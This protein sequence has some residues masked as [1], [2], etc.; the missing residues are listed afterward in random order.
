MAHQHKIGHSS[1]QEQQMTKTIL[2]YCTNKHTA[3]LDE[4]KSNSGLPV[5]KQMTL[6]SNNSS[7]VQSAASPFTNHDFCSLA[8]NLHETAAANWTTSRLYNAPT[9]HW[10]AAATFKQTINYDHPANSTQPGHPSM[11]WGNKNQ[12]KLHV[13]RHT[14]WCTSLITM[15]LQC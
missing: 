4:S 11:A 13:N 2:Q 12:W 8:E 7:L 10:K 6:L 9:I 1:V 14:A 15:V 5:S 3:A